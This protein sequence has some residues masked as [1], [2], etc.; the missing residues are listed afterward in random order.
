M[1]L[2][3]PPP[4]SPTAQLTGDSLCSGWI[5]QSSERAEDASPR[6]FAI[7]TMTDSLKLLLHPAALLTLTHLRILVVHNGLP[8]AEVTAFRP[9]FR[10]RG[11]RRR[12]AGLKMDRD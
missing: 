10:K 5:R 9:C 3:Y 12:A 2:F 8:A 1:H 11:G 4:P 7:I 6:L